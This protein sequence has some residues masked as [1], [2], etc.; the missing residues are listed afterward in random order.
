MEPATK[1]TRPAT[2][3]SS[4]SVRGAQR[5]RERARDMGTPWNWDENDIE[6]GRSRSDG[7]DLNNLTPR[8]GRRFEAIQ[9]LEGSRRREVAQVAQVAKHRGAPRFQ[10]YASRSTACALRRAIRKS[11]RL[12]NN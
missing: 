3:R 10:G 8:V 7:W 2:T 12:Y 9:I 11:R 4:E 6:R 1:N 5:G